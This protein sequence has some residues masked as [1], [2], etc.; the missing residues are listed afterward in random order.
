MK[1]IQINPVSKT[2]MI[3][4]LK[5][6]LKLSKTNSINDIDLKSL[7]SD[8]NW[9]LLSKIFDCSKWKKFY[10]TNPKY[11]IL[12]C[13]KPNDPELFMIQCTLCKQWFHPECVGSTEDKLKNIGEKDIW[14]CRYCNEDYDENNPIAFDNIESSNENENENQNENN[15][16]SNQNGNVN[17]SDTEIDSDDD[18]DNSSTDSI[19]SDDDN[20]ANATFRRKLNNN[21]VEDIHRNGLRRS[22]RIQSLRASANGKSEIEHDN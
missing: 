5:R 7:E 15:A 16:I 18:N 11:C 10:D 12:S 3:K 9:Q 21:K 22:A 20:H 14:W 13:K 1:T 6:I 17:A 2:S 4:G 19:D 8:W